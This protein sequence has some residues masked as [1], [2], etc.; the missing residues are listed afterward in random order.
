MALPKSGLSSLCWRPSQ[1]AVAAVQGVTGVL[2]NG[3]VAADSQFMAAVFRHGGI[4]PT[5]PGQSS[6]V[7]QISSL[8]LTFIDYPCGSVMQMHAYQPYPDA[9]GSSSMSHAAKLLSKCGWQLHAAAYHIPLICI[10][11]TSDMTLSNNTIP[12]ENDVLQ[13]TV[14]LT[15]IVFCRVLQ[16]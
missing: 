13:K 14:K 2:S 10:I 5:D 4:L 9:H 8:L 6:L 11:R 7:T 15:A 3:N 16:L 1:T 12:I